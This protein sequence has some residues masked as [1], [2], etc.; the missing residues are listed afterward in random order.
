MAPA[1]ARARR[2]PWGRWIAAALLVVPIAEIAVIIAV[3][4]VIGGWPTFLLLLAE[5]LFGAWLVRRE[6]VSAWRALVAA[7]RAGTMPAGELADAALVLVGGT[8]L[9][10]PGFITDLVGFL[11]VLPWTRPVARTALQAAVASRLV[12]TTGFGPAAPP[13]GGAS[14]SG[15]SGNEEATGGFAGGQVIEGEILDDES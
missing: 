6:G 5:S 9:L 2:V 13:G 10:T 7:L 3:G 4:R 1:V 15:S 8:L 11:V 12:W 14:A